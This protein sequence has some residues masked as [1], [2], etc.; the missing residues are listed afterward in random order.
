MLQHLMFLLL[1]L[2]WQA[3]APL[4]GSMAATL[5]DGPASQETAAPHKPASRSDEASPVPAAADD[6]STLSDVSR[7]DAPASGPSPTSASIEAPR[8]Q[9]Q[10]QRVYIQVDRRTDAKGYVETEDDEV[11]VIRWK[12]EVQSF[13]KG[14]VFRIIRLVD[15][16][17]GQKGFVVL[18]DGQVRR[19]TIIRDD[20]DEVVLGIE[21]IRSVFPRELV[22]HVEL[23]PT[24]EQ[25]LEHMRRGLTE[26]N[27]IGRYELARWLFEQRRYDMSRD[28]LAYILERTEMPEAR[29][30][31]RLVDAQLILQRSSSRSES[32][33]PGPF[34]SGREEG[35]SRSGPVHQRD[36]LPDRLLS[37][38]DVNL[39]RVYEMDLSKSPKLSI[40]Q[41]TIRTMIERYGASD[42][43][44]A[45]SEARTALL[46]S[47]PVHI[48]RLLFRLKARELYPQIEVLSEPD[49]LN[50]FRQ[51][52]HN[53]WLMN[54]C[55]TSRCHG[56]V[57]AGRL[58]LH[59]RNYKDERV[60]YTNLLILDSLEFDGRPLINYDDPMM[61]LVIQYGLPRNEARLPHPNVRG[62]RPAFTNANARLLEDAVAWIRGMY[63]PRPKYPVDFTPPDLSAPDAASAPA[64]REDR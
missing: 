47:D 26:N 44:P 40:S 56:G 51:R 63:Q 4:S 17:P 1:A 32:D 14:R 21:G 6:E 52:V 27:F 18:R 39:I 53:T 59:N 41:A 30:L 57:D 58:F 25:R 15:P 9:S 54:N 12:D 19:G 38:E 43:I 64:G 42:L 10:R 7:D 8:D 3:A 35:G 29:H 36:L 31:L 45:R 62:W 16:L 46:R 23:E 2:A 22:D 55:A 48:A 37:H 28:E 50:L 34:E 49:H 60:R 5:Q 20:F 33:G 13:A 24:F 11:I 61:S